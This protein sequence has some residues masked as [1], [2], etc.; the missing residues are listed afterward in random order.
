MAINFYRRIKKWKNKYTAH[1]ERER[2]E[3]ANI[4]PNIYKRIDKNT[5]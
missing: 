1:R 3:D 5:L 4:L 2:G